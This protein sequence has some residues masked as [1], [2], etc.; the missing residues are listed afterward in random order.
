MKF[1]NNLDKS[2]LGNGC[3]L[4]ATIFWGVNYPFTK[5]LIPDF[6]SA[7]DISAVRL[8]GGCILFWLTSLFTGAEKLDA[9]SLKC[10]AIGGAVGLFGCI[11]LFVLSLNYG[12]A[13]DIAIIMTLPPVFVILME[14]LFMGRRPS[15]MEYC[16]IVLSFAGAAMIILS[17]AGS[18]AAGGNNFLLGDFLA[19]AS[20]LSFAIYLVVLAKPTDKYRPISLLRWVFFFA[21]LPAL[22]LVPPLFSAPILK[23]GEIAPWLEI[24]FILFCP[25]FLAY[26][27][28][29]PAIRMIGPV[30]D[31]LYQYLTPVVAAIAAILMGVDE[32]RWQ[33]GAAMLIIIAGMILTD[34]G[35]KREKVNPAHEARKQNF[36]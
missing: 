1:R 28:Q 19:M 18:G 4:V 14:V 12:S 9:Q 30:I 16:G 31:S 10:A 2:L 5:A 36:F 24:A 8:V 15:L 17:R 26:L 3:I 22:F 21:A 29:E 7:N 11:F 25:T 32:P 6:M 35:K 27:L 33:Q 20:S 13:I 23:S 34:R